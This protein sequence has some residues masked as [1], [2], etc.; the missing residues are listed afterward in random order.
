LSTELLIAAFSIIHLTVH[1]KWKKI[2]YKTLYYESSIILAVGLLSWTGFYLMGIL[3]DKNGV[4]TLLTGT[5]Y[6]PIQPIDLIFM[7]LGLLVSTALLDFLTKFY[8]LNREG[9]LAILPWTIV[10]QYR[11]LNEFIWVYQYWITMNVQSG[12]YS[13]SIQWFNG[14]LMPALLTHMWALLFIV[15]STFNFVVILMESRQKRN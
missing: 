8:D 10:G 5:W 6:F 13:D 11:Y 7:G 1:L 12:K 4:F 14:T 2:R 3:L 15:F 9:L